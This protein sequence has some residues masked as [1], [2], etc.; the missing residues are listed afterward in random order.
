[1]AAEAAETASR[2]AYRGQAVKAIAFS[3]CGTLRWR[4][5]GSM[6]IVLRVTFG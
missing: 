3:G 1:M 5:C 6:S 4:P 2:H